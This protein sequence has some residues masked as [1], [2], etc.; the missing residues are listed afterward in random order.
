[1]SSIGHS[2]LEEESS[3]DG[4]RFVSAR[5]ESLD[6]PRRAAWLISLY[7]PDRPGSVVSARRG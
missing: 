7:A 4:R 6:E 2:I 5:L 3:L 1:M